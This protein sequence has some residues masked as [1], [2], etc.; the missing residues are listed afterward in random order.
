M[1]WI[2]YKVCN[3]IFSVVYR[4]FIATMYFC[5]AILVSLIHLCNML[6]LVFPSLWSTK[7]CSVFII[8]KF[9]PP[10][11]SYSHHID[12]VKDVILSSWSFSRCILLRFLSI[13]FHAF[14]EIAMMILQLSN[15]EHDDKFS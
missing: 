7:V 4:P 15:L 14:L 8:L 1:L 12:I 9:C 11:F 10:L 6:F 13:K 3:V 2:V 5:A